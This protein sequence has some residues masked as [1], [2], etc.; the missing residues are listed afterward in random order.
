MIDYDRTAWWRVVFSFGGTVLPRV[1]GRVGCLTLWSL[2]LCLLDDSVLRLYGCELPSLDQLGHVVL[3]TALSLLIVFRTNSAY[4][5]FWEARS[6]WGGIVNASRNLARLAAAGAPPADDVGR[7]LTAFALCLKQTLRGSK[8]FAELRHLVAGRVYERLGT[9]ADPPG[10]L[11]R[12]LSD[13]VGR[14][15]AAGRLNPQQAT[16]MDALVCAL[17][18]Q[19]GGCEKIR[20]TPLPFVYATLIKQVVLLY[21]VSLP[22]VLVAKMG[23]AA[24]LV[25]AAVSFGLFG[26]ED[27]GV[28]IENPFEAEPNSLPL[29]AICETITRNVS[30]AAGDK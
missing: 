21:L 18:D 9:A 12:A 22:F 27:A 15:L 28:E 26:I 30:E 29:D 23:Y 11:A 4:Q 5:R 10:V 3:G 2:G 17:V 13:W 6:H 24:P 14:A 25:V 19:Q 16:Q 20:R 8:D 7:L 1:L